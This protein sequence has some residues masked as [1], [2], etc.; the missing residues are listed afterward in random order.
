VVGGLTLREARVPAAARVRDSIRSVTLCASCPDDE[1]EI[2]PL[3]ELIVRLAVA[4]QT[5][6]DRPLVHVFTDPWVTKDVRTRRG[7]SPPSSTTGR[8]SWTALASPA[9]TDDPT[10]LESPWLVWM[11]DVLT[12]ASEPTSSTSPPTG[13]CRAGAAT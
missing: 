2:F 6:P 3:T 8:Q 9:S 5:L 12:S 1:K 4:A 10:A 7:R 13:I 11:K